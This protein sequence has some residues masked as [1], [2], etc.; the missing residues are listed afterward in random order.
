MF[1]HDFSLSPNWNVSGIFMIALLQRHSL[2]NEKKSTK[3]SFFVPKIPTDMQ[4]E[5]TWGSLCEEL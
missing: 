1:H 2:C 3:L 4:S 5:L